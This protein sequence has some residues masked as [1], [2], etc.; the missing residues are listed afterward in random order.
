MTLAEKAHEYAK[1]HPQE[2][3]LAWIDNT[4][5]IYKADYA[6]RL[7]GI[8]RITACILGAECGDKVLEDMLNKLI[9]RA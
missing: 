8:L 9:D 2:V 7:C 4:Q 5:R 6:A 1:Q 3:T